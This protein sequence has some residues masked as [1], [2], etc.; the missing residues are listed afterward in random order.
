MYTQSMKGS[1]IGLQT[2]AASTVAA[3]GTR[4]VGRREASCPGASCWCQN[5]KPGEGRGACGLTGLHQTSL[6][7]LAPGLNRQAK[8]RAI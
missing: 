3:D 8:A 2:A 6:V 5:G 7:G 4:T 1:Q